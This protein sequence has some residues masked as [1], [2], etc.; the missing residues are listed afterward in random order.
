MLTDRARE[1]L[2][3]RVQSNSE[4]GLGP[5]VRNGRAAKAALIALLAF[6]SLSAGATIV[7]LST[8]QSVNTSASNDLGATASDNQFPTNPPDFSASS[9][10]QVHGAF[11]YAEQITS[12]SPLA[13]QLH[14]YA[15]SGA[16]SGFY[17]PGVNFSQSEAHAFFQISFLVTESQPFHL[18]GLRNMGS[19]GGVTA[20]LT[21][22]DGHIPLNWINGGTEL[23]TYGV[24]QPNTYTLTGRLDIGS[25]VPNQNYYTEN[26]V[27][28]ELKLQ[29]FPIPD[30]GPSTAMLGI[31]IGGFLAV[32]RIQVRRRG[33]RKLL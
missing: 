25:V 30:A 12:C 14:Q 16:A 27:G 8:S 5:R 2:K 22:S 1:D 29:T 7:T 10:S 28:L 17:A 24:L 18:T 21:S 20:E 33:S 26:T 19:W 11:G 32:R 9:I 23:D 6:S 3:S 13:I 31:V 15:S 4:I